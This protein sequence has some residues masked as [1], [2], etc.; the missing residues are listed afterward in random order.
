MAVMLSESERADLASR[1]NFDPKLDH[2]LA[3]RSM[4]VREL[5]DREKCEVYLELWARE[6]GSPSRR[7]AASMLAKR[8]AFLT[9]SPILYAMTRYNKGIQLTL[10]NCRL[11]SPSEA[12]YQVNKSRFPNLYVDEWQVTEPAAEKRQEWRE[13]QLRLLFEGH[14][15]PLFRSL[16]VAGQV[17]MAILWEN[18]LVRI[19]PI[20]EDGLEE[21]EDSLC[22]QQLH[23]D[24][25]YITRTAPASIFGTRRNPFTSFIR[26]RDEEAAQEQR[27]YSRQTCC[28]YYE[29]S[30][31]YCQACPKTESLSS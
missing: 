7:V 31:E 24:L 11:V 27:S 14:V 17:P 29:M 5:L 20:Y 25:H 22:V 2:L 18:A 9:I 16:S 10:D 15:F 8:Y 19:I 1:Y 4:S 6:I 21:E 13:Q 30:P 3:A 26:A 28:F 23:D 12:E